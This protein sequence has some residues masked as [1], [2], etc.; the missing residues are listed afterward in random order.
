MNHRRDTGLVL[1]L[2]LVIVVVIAA[3][4]AAIA[5]YATTTIRYGQVVE[6]SADRLAAA[7]GAMDNALEALDRGTSLCALTTLA[8]GDGYQYDLL[9]PAA[10]VN[11]INGIN[12]RIHCRTMGAAVTGIEEFALVLTGDPGTGSRTGAIL[13]VAGS[14]TPRKVIDGPVFMGQRPNQYDTLALSAPLT[15]QRGDLWYGRSTCPAP[16]VSVVPYPL[17]VDNLL[18]TPAGYGIRC[19]PTPDWETLFQSARP[20]ETAVTGPTDP[21]PVTDSAGCTVF[22]PGR[23]TAPPVLG[24][25]NYFSS[26]T[27]WLD[28]VGDWEI[29]NA[30]ALFGWPGAAGPSIQGTGADTLIDNTCVGAWEADADQGGAT[31]YLGGNSRISIGANG[32]LEISGRLQGGRLVSLQALETPGVESVIQGD[33]PAGSLPLPTRLIEVGSGNRKQIAL[34]GLLW[35]PYA[36]IDL[37]N[38]SN[39]AVAA[40]AGGAVVSEIFLQASGS[41]SNFLVESGSTPGERRL[42]LTATAT[43]SDGATTAVRA[44][45]LYRDSEYALESRRV[46]CITPGEPD[47]GGC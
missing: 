44:V 46:M 25:Y 34:D 27:Y 6:R 17:G 1:P 15:I 24:T 5:T 40:L 43:S 22:E 29:A 21:P 14:D 35:A 12:P 10:A 2:V 37:R 8:N 42:E 47:P 45:V 18:I 26:G 7:N 11:S 41:A 28:D 9:Q 30:Y 33:D 3:V 23:Y 13:N 4:V 32:S 38:V 36:S 20:P 19:I 16:D 31:L 39:D